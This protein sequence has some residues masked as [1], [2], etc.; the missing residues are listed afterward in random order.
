MTAG[1]GSNTNCGTFGCGTVFKLTRTTSGWTE[2][3]LYNFTGAS[4][5]A[6]PRSLVRDSEGNLY[7]AA[8]SG[9]Q[10]FGGTRFK[11]S[12]DGHFTILHSF[13]GGADGANPQVGL[14]IERL[15]PV[16]IGAASAGGDPNC[17]GFGLPGCGVVFA[18]VP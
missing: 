5:G 2:S 13:T 10:S 12:P 9:G 16:I 8:T 17:K 7:G 3:V 14:V 11:L 15:Q 4:D 6:N 1:G 18:Y